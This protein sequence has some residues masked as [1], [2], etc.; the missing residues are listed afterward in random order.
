MQSSTQFLQST[1]VVS[2][3]WPAVCPGRFGIAPAQDHWMHRYKGMADCLSQKAGTKD[4]VC[5][6]VAKSAG[7]DC[8]CAGW[9][10]DCVH[11]RIWVWI[12]FESK[13]GLAC[14]Y[15]TYENF[16]PG[17]EILLE[18]CRTQMQ[19]PTGSFAKW[20]AWICAEPWGLA[21]H[22]GWLLTAKANQTVAK[23]LRGPAMLGPH[24]PRC[25]G[26]HPSLP[27]RFAP[28]EGLLQGCWETYSVG[29]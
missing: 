15:C 27:G 13:S 29:Y 20:E 6:W 21:E 7:W 22:R 24:P 28:R 19:R 1:E 17:N 18:T 4:S 5:N 11:L 2:T 14:W 8:Y 12:A 10:R 3:T 16:S 23:T 9:S 26:M 25:W